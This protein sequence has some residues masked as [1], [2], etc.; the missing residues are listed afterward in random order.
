MRLKI[1]EYIIKN[2]KPDKWKDHAAFWDQILIIT[3]EA[4][5]GAVRKVLDLF[6][7]DTNTITVELLDKLKSI[8]VRKKILKEHKGKDN[9][10]KKAN[11][12][13]FLQSNHFHLLLWNEVCYRLGLLIYGNDHTGRNSYYQLRR[14]MRMMQTNPT[15]GIKEYEQRMTQLES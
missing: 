6:H 15:T 9:A 2:C 5:K 4:A 13:A 3:A 1:N 8:I 11:L 12:K 7:P 14:V 10:E